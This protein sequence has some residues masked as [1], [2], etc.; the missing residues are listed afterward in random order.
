MRHGGILTK[1]QLQN[2]YGDCT[3]VGMAASTTIPAVQTR[4]LTKRYG[5]VVAVDRLDLAV[6]TGSV[7]ALLGPN[8]AG[9]TTTV[10]MIATLVTPTSGTAAVCGHD[11]VGDGDA[12]RRRIALTGQFAALD[13]NLTGRENL[14]LVAALRGHDRATARRIADELIERFDAGDFAGRTISK[15]SGGQRRRM[16]LA[17]SLVHQP[18][19]LVLD[20]PTTGLDPRSR[21]IVWSTVRELVNDG[22]TLL[23]TTQYLE[24][25]DALADRIVLIDHGRQV[26]AGTVA[27]L[28]RTVGAQRIDVVAVDAEGLEALRAR[29]AERFD[30]T[31]APELRTLSIPAPDEVED[32]AGVTEAVR[33]AG[34]P[35]D[36]LALRRP[37]LDDAFLA[38]TGRP[39][40]QDES[41]SVLAAE[42]A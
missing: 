5:D 11:V 7:V 3:F 30:V 41:P 33:A 39:P 14:R 35:V 9:K 17:A 23:L 38:L 34:V 2:F 40:A 13:P 37:S 24:E 6:D 21:Q 27:E 20:E 31:V 42:A 25:A 12:V 36:E 29:L 8:G 32:L 19:L 28:K 15:V 16:D 4:G 1:L 22:V 26:A 10:R 18:A